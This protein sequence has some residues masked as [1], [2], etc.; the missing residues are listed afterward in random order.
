MKRFVV[1]VS[2]SR[3]TVTSSKERENI[4]LYT[5]YL[6]EL[7][8]MNKRHYSVWTPPSVLQFLPILF[9]SFPLSCFFFFLFFLATPSLCCLQAE[10][11]E[12]GVKYAESLPDSPLRC[13]LKSRHSAGMKRRTD[14][15]Q[16]SS[17]RNDP[18]AVRRS[19]QTTRRVAHTTFSRTGSRLAARGLCKLSGWEAEWISSRRWSRWGSIRLTWRCSLR[20]SPLFWLVAVICLA[21]GWLKGGLEP[22]GL[23]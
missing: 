16:A 6:L 5:K 8:V 21:P 13:L 20:Q 22:T 12:L 14:P 15:A 17:V 1:S 18:H 11:G 3:I 9:L 10:T 4:Y 2:D 23:G 19:F 7:L